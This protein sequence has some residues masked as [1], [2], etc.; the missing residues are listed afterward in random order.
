VRRD[1]SG[2][3]SGSG[4]FQGF[5]IT[6]LTNRPQNCSPAIAWYSRARVREN[7]DQK[8]LEKREKVSV[9]PKNNMHGGSGRRSVVRV[10]VQRGE[11]KTRAHGQC[12]RK[13]EP[14]N[15]LVRV[16]PSVFKYMIHVSR[17]QG[18]RERKRTGERAERRKADACVIV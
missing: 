11:S 14:E 17:V 4:S 7:R 16:L 10:L 9:R 5:I 3:G 2:S 1:W 8:S 6:S 18:G 13:A 15:L 12:R